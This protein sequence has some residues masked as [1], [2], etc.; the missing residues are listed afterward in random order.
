MFP[1][2]VAG[3]SKLEFSMLIISNVLTSSIFG[4]QTRTRCH[5]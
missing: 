3:K 1:G 5:D 4:R 2:V